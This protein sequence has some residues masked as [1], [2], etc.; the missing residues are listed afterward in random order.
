MSAIRKRIGIIAKSLSGSFNGTMIAGI[1]HELQKHDLEAIAIQ[2]P[3]TESSPLYNEAYGLDLI[4]G[5]IVLNESA[6]PAFFETIYKRNT[7]IVSVNRIERSSPCSSIIV[8]NVQGMYIATEHLIQHGHKQ[9]AFIGDLTNPNI[10]RRFEGYKRALNDYDLTYN[11]ELTVNTATSSYAGSYAAAEVLLKK[12]GLYSAFVSANDVIAAGFA[13]MLK[14]EGLAIPEN[15]AGFGF[16]NDMNSK[17]DHIS[18]VQLPA[19]ELG[20]Q[21]VL[22]IVDQLNGNEVSETV[23]LPCSLVLRTSC[24]CKLSEL[25]EQEKAHY[26]PVFNDQ[27]IQLIEQ[28]RSV[29]LHL[30]RD[31][32]LDLLR[33]TWLFDMKIGGLA[34]WQENEVGVKQLEMNA[35]FN[36]DNPSERLVNKQVS[37]E[38]FPPVEYFFNQGVDDA[39]AT[40]DIAYLYILDTER[41]EHGVLVF[42]GTFPQNTEQVLG[43]IMMSML[44]ESVTANMDLD[45]ILAETKN[46]KDSYQSIAQQ[47][48]TIT[49]MT[50][51]GIWVMDFKKGHIHWYNN[52]IHDILGL[53]DESIMA[54]PQA[55]LDYIHPSDRDHVRTIFRDHIQNK[56]PFHI[57]CRLLKKDGTH[58]WVASH[59]KALSQDKEDWRIIGSIQD[60]T[61]SKLA[62]E[63]IQYLAFHDALTG[64]LNRRAFVERL[65][66]SIEAIGDSR[67]RLAIIFFDLDRFKMI[68]DSYGHHVGDR[69]LIEVAQRVKAQ[70]PQ[71]AVFCRFGGDEFMIMLPQVVQREE[72]ARLAQSIIDSFIPSFQYDEHEFHLGGSLGLSV[73]PDD[74][75]HA[76]TLVK[77]ADIAMRRAKN[78]GKNQMEWYSPEMQLHTEEWLSVENGLVKA[79]Q[80][81]EFVLHYQPQIYLE[82][83]RLVGAEALVR[84]NSAERGLVPPHQFIPIAEETGLIV[85]MGQM[86]LRQACEQMKQWADRYELHDRFV[87]SVN[88]SARQF[89]QHHFVNNVRQIIEETGINPSMLCLEITESMAINDIDFYI[90]QLAEL[91]KLGLHLALDDFGTGYSS[92]DVLRR[93]PI[94]VVK[95]DR[96]FIQNIKTNEDDLAIVQSIISLSHKLNK[97]VVAEGVEHE[98][99]R[100]L[101]SEAKCDFFQGFLISKPIPSQSFEDTFLG[102][103]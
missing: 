59:C 14:K 53:D 54:S 89:E 30:V 99:H 48:S 51:D 26:D 17:M 75:D 8:D 85:P 19:F 45:H 29:N 2:I 23:T 71:H 28:F 21:A 25:E 39:S 47:L 33:A 50:S 65:E 9:I 86:I 3:G 57:V 64:L 72:I 92:L 82:N 78:S 95:I 74:G 4:D 68:N 60:I 87:C 91:S 46:Q 66:D 38:Q 67:E 11:P 94:N 62:D 80:N 15:I 44:A 100:E 93:L 77:H 32:E 76:T 58:I 42:S 83:G 61:A 79:L 22:S 56:Q 16:N 70:L 40:H 96:S 1:I 31:R 12:V 103:S 34:I 20:Q 6:S 18:T 43:V 101:L 69:V 5:W 36:S 10:R 81:D 41:S 24:G 27:L 49:E 35:Y 37:S 98:A 88:I 7:P 102:K 84:W 73:Y 52:L 97:L 63:Q 55:F 13:A 90:S